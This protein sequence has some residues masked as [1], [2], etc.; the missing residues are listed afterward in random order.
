MIR[1]VDLV[2]YLPPFLE[3]YTE[4]QEALKAEE[5]EFTL[6]W[7][8]TDRLLKNVFISTADEY[9]ISRME[10]IM[11]IASSKKPLEE[12]RRVVLAKSMDSIPY[13][14]PRLREFLEGLCGEEGYDLALLWE[15]YLLKVRIR[16]QPDED[17]LVLI[18]T[19]KDI[20]EQW[21]PC[22]M[23]YEFSMFEK[24][25]TEVSCFCGTA[26]SMVETYHV[27]VK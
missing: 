22:N 20:M 1:D 3:K 11:G 18:D 15:T 4:L 8:A 26:V 7:E 5:P 9:G 19:I 21:R 2:S 6:L 10:S 16:G 13:T 17:G 27:E 23:N 24:H 25:E 14:I 12:R